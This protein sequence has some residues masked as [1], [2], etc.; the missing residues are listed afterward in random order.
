[1]K[2]NGCGKEIP[3]NLKFCKYCGTPVKKEGNVDSSVDTAKVFCM[4]CGAPLKPGVVFCT[5][6][7]TRV[8]D[9]QVNGAATDGISRDKEYVR[10]DDT[11][12]PSIDVDDN[13]KG[14]GTVGKYIIIILSIVS[15]ILIGIIAVYF[16]NKSGLLDK[17]R[18]RDHTESAAKNDATA[19]AEETSD[20]QI[21]FTETNG[22]VGTDEDKNTSADI[23]QG[24]DGQDMADDSDVP[25]ETD[26]ESEPE[27]G[28]V[29][30][31]PKPEPEIGYD[32]ARHN[33]EFYQEDVTWTQAKRLCEERGG[34]LVTFINEEEWNTVCDYLTF[35]KLNYSKKPMHIWIGA[36][37]DGQKDGVCQIKPVVEGQAGISNWYQ[38]E[39]NHVDPNSGEEERYIK[40]VYMSDDKAGYYGNWVW[41][42]N[43]DDISSYFAG[44]I[45]YICEYDK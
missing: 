15:L 31:E 13:K 34:H 14:G 40:M 43:P 16:A 22:T 35:L 8:G 4:A 41:M 26:A 29:E 21:R 9:V 45:G 39:P 5:Q 6:C 32:P 19:D 3:D 30:E 20:E 36:Y 10:V 12:K 1:M 28:K 24:D 33:Y 7:G 17:L 23:R 42:D 2:C 25:K 44:R 38:G 18:N 37:C 11:K 27:S